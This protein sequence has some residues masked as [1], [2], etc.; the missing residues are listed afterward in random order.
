MNN[1]DLNIFEFLSLILRNKKNIIFSIIA[2]ILIGLIGYS[3]QKEKFRA[4]LLI[5]PLSL[6][7]FNNFYISKTKI[8]NSNKSTQ[9]SISRLD[10]SPYTLFHSY[11][12]ELQEVKNKNNMNKIEI[13]W[14][15]YGGEHAIH[16]SIFNHINKEDM[17]N[18]INKIT[19]DANKN[20]LFKLRENIFNEIKL[21][22]TMI[23][24][25]I[26]EVNSLIFKKKIIKQNL[27]KLD[28]VNL[29]NIKSIRSESSKIDINLIIIISILVGLCV[30]II[31]ILFSQYFKN[32]KKYK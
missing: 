4:T 19:T 2:F 25:E 29:V 3:A 11:L 18:E 32:K 28:N 1:K 10:I 31:Q 16:I 9:D 20:L 8:D 26:Y 15:P 30:G 13:Q 23:E 24:S 17:L 12:N 6:I 27:E 22:D 14:T 7:E 5:N 21:I